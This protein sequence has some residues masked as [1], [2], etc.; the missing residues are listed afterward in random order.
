MESSD[1]ERRKERGSFI[2]G[3]DHVMRDVEIA[4]GVIAKWR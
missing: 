1:G 4:K 3:M 2:V